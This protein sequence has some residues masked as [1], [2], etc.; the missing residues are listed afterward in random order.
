MSEGVSVNVKGSKRFCVTVSPSPNTPWLLW[1]WSWFDDFQKL[2]TA[3][4]AVHTQ[5]RESIIDD[6]GFSAYRLSA[7]GHAELQDSE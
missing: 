1:A 6:I 7:L 4:E 2:D 5:R 3:L